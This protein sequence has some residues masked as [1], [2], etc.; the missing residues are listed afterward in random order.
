M[1]FYLQG[2]EEFAI[3]GEDNAKS[4]FSVIYNFY[5]PNK[6]I[7]FSKDG[8]KETLPL[9]KNKKSLN[10]K[11]TVYMCKDYHCEAP[12]TSIEELKKTLAK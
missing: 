6:I 2:A 10:G 1:D 8:S 3:I 12:I 4:V 11:T 9:L 7:A 5:L